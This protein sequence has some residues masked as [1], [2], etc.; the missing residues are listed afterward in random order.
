MF[1]TLNLTYIF[2]LNILTLL[3]KFLLIISVNMMCAIT[4]VIHH[5]LPNCL[6]NNKSIF[7]SNE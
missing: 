7:F 1:I 5:N 2:L 4:G 6:F 3:T